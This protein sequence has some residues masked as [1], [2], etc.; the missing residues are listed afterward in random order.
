MP[1]EP[2]F[3]PKEKLMQT[4]E[5][6]DLA[7]LFISEGVRKIRLTGGEPLVRNDFPKI[8]AGI[9]ALRSNGLQELTLTTN[10]IFI[11]D[12]LNALQSAGVQS[13]NISLDTLLPERF[14][15]IAKRDHF[16]RVI[17]NIHLLLDKQFN[18]K[19]NVVVMKGVNDD[20]VIDFVN[21]TRDYP[22][23]VRFIEFM[24]FA[25]NKWQDKR[26]IR[27]S[28]L[29]GRVKQ[30]LDVEPL[31]NKKHD[32]S[33][34]FKVLGYTGTFAFISTM[35]EPFC[36]DCNRL[37]LTADGKIKNCLFSKGEL[38]L[39]A[40]LRNGQD[41]RPVLHKS[42]LQKEEKW[43]GQSLFGTTENR[44]MVAIGG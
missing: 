12:H 42:L 38:D 16:H 5:V 44:S 30:F 7:R 14:S 28:E 29:L 39:L 3:S 26:L 9:A 23:H 13:L 10:G 8:I 20:E 36:G 32:T 11:H 2:D 18:V 22:L 1:E 15:A 19:V 40:A 43:G 37:R 17:S 31:E 24:P 4:E 6:I 21:W 34:A 33:R 25:G 27:S 35:S 41:P